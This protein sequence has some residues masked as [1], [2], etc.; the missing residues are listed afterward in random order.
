MKSIR[1][2]LLLGFTII[3]LLVAG[4]SIFTIYNTSR[5][6]AIAEEMINDDIEEFDMYQ[7]LRFNVAERIAV[8]RGYLLYGDP[9][10]KE[11]FFAYT[12]ESK[13]LEEKLKGY[14][15][16]EE[17][18]FAQEIITKSEMW[19][20]K[21]TQEVYNVY[22]TNPEQAI[23][24]NKGI[25]SQSE[26]L[27]LLLSQAVEKE[28]TT[29][30]EM[31]TSII[32]KGIATERANFIVS[33]CVILSGIGIAF[34]VSHIITKP[35]LGV[36]S[37]LKN[38]ANGDFTGEDM[39]TS[40]QDEV[41][42]LIT[43]MNAMNTELRHIIRQVRTTSES[44]AASS[45]ELTASA[46]G[47]VMAAQQISTSINDVSEGATSQL[48]S[49]QSSHSI[50]S[51]IAKGMNEVASSITSVAEKT[52]ETTKQSQIGNDIVQQTISGMKNVQSHVG[53]TSEVISMLA[54][55]SG[56]I[57]QIVELISV[58]S[59]QTNLL[60]LNAAIEAA[61]A[62][63]HGKGF[64]VV[65]DE[66][67]KLAEESG[68]AAGQISELILAIQNETKKAVLS[69]EQGIDSVTEGMQLVNQTGEA[70]SVISESVT[71]ISE[72]SQ[73][74]SA[75]VQQI[76]AGTET[77]KESISNVAS[78]SELSSHNA[79]NVS[80]STQ[81]SLASIEEISSSSAS[82]AHMAEELQSLVRKFKI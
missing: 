49:I 37:Y 6:N 79:Q 60:A 2:K 63:E 28:D 59:S 76:T 36:I 16:D 78:I 82:L 58:I 43:A 32:S 47:T 22:E 12:K 18:P 45:E 9:T 51:E 66:V 3:L 46:E 62:G 77:M 65:A 19:G 44:V 50:V 10:L 13:I 56:E 14:L 80:A 69:M 75:I 17:R 67:K 15:S 57:G 35:I 74:V 48:R 41:G 81:E 53:Q 68:K 4:M 1:T 23:L 11:K 30:T 55:K 26:E 24:N 20:E 5:T 27:M 72:Q 31:G 39:N 70:F 29:V 73:E 25:R 7:T 38:M 33:I 61:R 64:A 52:V 42:V 54:K 8:T 40:S 21:L 34:Y 71:F